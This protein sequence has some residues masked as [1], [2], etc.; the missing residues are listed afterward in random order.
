MMSEVNNPQSSGF[1]PEAELFKPSDKGKNPEATP[2]EPASHSGSGIVTGSVVKPDNIIKTYNMSDWAR[3]KSLVYDS[4]IG[5]APAQYKKLQRYSWN[6]TY[7]LSQE[8]FTNYYDKM[9]VAWFNHA[10]AEVETVNEKFKHDLAKGEGLVPTGVAFTRGKSNI[11]SNLR[12]ELSRISYS[13]LTNGTRRY[14]TFYSSVSKETMGDRD[15]NIVRNF[16]VKIN[17]DNS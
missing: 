4:N 13:E 15:E 11:T 5:R 3:G 8:Q 16:H 17:S 6:S 12:Y 7:T 10:L 2:F 14:P 9:R 1:N